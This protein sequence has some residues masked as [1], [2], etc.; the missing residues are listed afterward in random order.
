MLKWSK[1]FSPKI[2]RSQ[3]LKKSYKYSRFSI[4][5]CASAGVV[6]ESIVLLAR[7]LSGRGMDSSFEDDKACVNAELVYNQKLCAISL[8]QKVW[9]SVYSVIIRA[10]ETSWQRVF[11][12]FCYSCTAWNGKYSD[13]HTSEYWLPYPI[14]FTRIRR[15]FRVG[16]SRNMWISWP[17]IRRNK[18]HLIFWVRN[19][20]DFY[21]N[22]VGKK[23]FQYL[24]LSSEY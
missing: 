8:L 20:S 24:W 11:L 6:C 23:I 18:T 16:Y 3:L 17:W 13:I 10:Q 9:V 22:I 19:I 1:I 21:K 12:E 4:W 15:F 7:F 14:V 5:W 2:R